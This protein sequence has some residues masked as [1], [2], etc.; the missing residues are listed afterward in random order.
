M[1]TIPDPKVPPAGATP[2][3]RIRAEIKYTNFLKA[4][5]E[6]ILNNPDDLPAQ[7]ECIDSAYAAYCSWWDSQFGA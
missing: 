4:A 7:Q 2:E 1:L 5:I 3:E 6:C